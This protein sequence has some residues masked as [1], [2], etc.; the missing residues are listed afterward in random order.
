MEMSTPLTSLV[1]LWQ[2]EGRQGTLTNLF[3]SLSPL[4]LPSLSPFS[5]PSAEEKEK[6]HTDVEETSAGKDHP[7]VEEPSV[8]K[9]H[10]DVEEPSAGKDHPDVEEPSAGKK[11]KVHS[12]VGEPQQRL[13]LHFLRQQGLVPEHIETRNLYTPTHPNNPQVCYMTVMCSL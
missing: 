4:F 2:R 6:D 13:A 10:P 11:K 3:S 7:D 9:D 12:D 5:L 1:S 8:G